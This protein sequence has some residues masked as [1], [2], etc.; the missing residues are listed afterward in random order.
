MRPPSPAELKGTRVLAMALD[1]SSAKV[2]SGPPVEEPEDYAR[3]VWAGVIPLRTETCA[4]VP[5]PRLMPGVVPSAAV[6]EWLRRR[7]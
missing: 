5:S 7:A 3:A 6:E 1:E 2:R 4:P